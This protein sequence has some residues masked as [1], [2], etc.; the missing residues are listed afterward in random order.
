VHVLR[1]ALLT[2]STRPR[3][4][5]VHTLA[6]AEALSRTGQDVT[7]WSLAHG[8]D[9][10]FFRPVDPAV[11]IRVVP[12]PDPDPGEEAGPRRQR[13][14]ALLSAAF[15]QAQEQ[16]ESYHVVH[17]QDCLTASAVPGRLRTVHRIERSADSVEL[18]AGQRRALVE[19][20]AHI[21]VSSSVALELQVETGRTAVVIPN[22][23]DAERFAAAAGDDPVAIGNRQRWNDRFGDYVLAVGGIEPRKG[24][25]D[26][27][28]AMARVRRRRPGTKLVVAGGHTPLEHRD[29]RRAVDALA[30]RLRVEPVVLGPVDHE[31][32]P[33]LVAAAAVFAFPS[34]QAGFGLV[35]LE[36]LAAGVPVVVRD[37]PAFREVFTDA[38]KGDSRSGDAVGFADLG[39]GSFGDV[40]AGLAIQLTAALQGQRAALAGVGRRF[41]ARHTWDDV[42]AA[43]LALYRQLISEGRPIG[44]DLPAGAASPAGV[45]SP[46]GAASAL[47][48]APAVGAVFPVGASGRADADGRVGT[49]GRAGADERTGTVRTVSSTVGLELT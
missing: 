16:G 4:D 21:C 20:C 47:G 24:T 17:A 29:Y 23:V 34:V 42:A 11:R 44:T 6:L 39:D 9:V 5:V 31:E 27:V 48:P 43:H 36:A 45:A 30:L 3:G 12:V 26:L 15:A 18:A 46:V 13:S 22:G 32:L 1:I 37:L 19:P 10:G 8:D 2:H 40:A 41:A 38:L 25:L 14:I 33:G 49:A 35:A 7:V 28:R